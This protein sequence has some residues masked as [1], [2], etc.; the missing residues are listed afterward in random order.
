MHT[1]GYATN[2]PQKVGAV[3]PLLGKWFDSKHVIYT[4]PN[5]HI[6][7]EQYYQEHV[8]GKSSGWK[9]IFEHTNPGSWRWH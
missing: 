1:G 4:L 7:V 9:K 8:D 2:N 6:K 3:D 5:G